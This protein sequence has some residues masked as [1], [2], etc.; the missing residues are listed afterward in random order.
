MP[1]RTRGLVRTAARTAVIAGTATSVSGR[2][3][4]RQQ[5]KLAHSMPQHA[6]PAGA[7]HAGDAGASDD[8]VGKLQQLADLK[9]AGALTDSEYKAAKAKVLA[10]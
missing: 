2:V 7:H 10:M 8:L 3:A 1:R 4:R 9:A 6:P 5:Q